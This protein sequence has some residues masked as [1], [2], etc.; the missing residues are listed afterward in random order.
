LAKRLFS[1]LFVKNDERLICALPRIDDMAKTAF[2]CDI[3][4]QGDKSGEA[5]VSNR[6][7]KYYIMHAKT[8]APMAQSQD[9]MPNSPSIND[10]C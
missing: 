10:G 9:T 5:I 2:N 3:I 4:M 6:G 7:I 1:P 8:I